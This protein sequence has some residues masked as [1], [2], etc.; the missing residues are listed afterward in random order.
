MSRLARSRRD[1]PRRA[2]VRSKNCQKAGMFRAW[3]EIRIVGK[4]AAKRI[5]AQ[6]IIQMFLTGSRM[7]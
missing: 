1:R 7:G 4:A 2:Q 6:L 3:A 5:I